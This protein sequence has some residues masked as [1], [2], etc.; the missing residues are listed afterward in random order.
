[1]LL[2]KFQH[3]ILVCISTGKEDL[4]IAIVGLRPLIHYALGRVW[5]CR[6]ICHGHLPAVSGVSTVSLSGRPPPLP[7][8]LLPPGHH[9]YPCA[10]PLCHIDHSP[11]S[12]RLPVNAAR[13]AIL[14]IATYISSF[15][16]CDSR[17]LFLYQTDS[18]HVSPT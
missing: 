5:S 1:M 2:F 15:L 14:F 3:Q 13:I 11:L 10:D 17:S 18:T 8:L 4:R 6:V 7:T 16:H 9:Q 12:L